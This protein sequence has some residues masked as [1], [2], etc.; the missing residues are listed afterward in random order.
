MRS[1]PLRYLENVI[2][3]SDK[4]IKELRRGKRRSSFI[5]TRKGDLRV[6]PG[7]LFLSDRPG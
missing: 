1:E 6:M 7:R 3:N 4:K 5:T 2:Y